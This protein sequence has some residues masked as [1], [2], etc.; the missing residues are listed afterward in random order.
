MSQISSTKVEARRN[1]S[2][3]FKPATLSGNTLLCDCF[4]IKLSNFFEMMDPSLLGCKDS[5]GEEWVLKFKTNFD[6]KR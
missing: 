5:Q 4:E 1:E 2:K 3:I 6:L